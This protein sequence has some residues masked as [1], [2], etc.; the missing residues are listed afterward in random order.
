MILMM[1]LIILAL[2]LI[3]AS[4][5]NYGTFKT[6]ECVNIIQTNSNATWA[7]ITSILNQNSTIL[8]SNIGMTKVGS[9]FNYTFCQTES[10]GKYQV[11]GFGDSDKQDFNFYFYVTPTGILQG[12]IWDNSVFIILLV[13]AIFFLVLASVLKNF[14]LGF[15]SGIMFL[16]SGVYTM[17]YGFN[18]YTDDF[19]RMVAFVLIGLGI[20][21]VLVSGYEGVVESGD[22]GIYNDE[23]GEG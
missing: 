23:E 16:V 15:I 12:S 3:S 5:E 9:E 20:I 17:I 22:Q 7:N 1:A 10:L 19:S 13:V 2:P 4:Q 11:N 14:W 6:L 18:N 21:F 8:V